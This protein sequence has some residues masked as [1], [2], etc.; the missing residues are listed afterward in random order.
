M[1]NTTRVPCLL[2]DDPPELVIRAQV[3]QALDA[4]AEPVR[5]AVLLRDVE[6]C[7]PAEIAE[8][9]RCPLATVKRFIHAGRL[10][11]RHKLAPL[12]DAG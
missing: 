12:L 4:L 9:L 1:W 6:G 3:C 2:E 7:T 11:L 5:S 10:E 8:I